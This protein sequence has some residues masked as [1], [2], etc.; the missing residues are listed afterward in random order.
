M[1]PLPPAPWVA[2]ATL[3]ACVVSARVLRLPALAPAGNDRLAS[4][5]GL[6]GMLALMVFFHHF[7]ITSVFKVSGQWVAPTS[8]V[9]NLFGTAGVSLFF[10]ITGF[11][12]FGKIKAVHG[13]IDLNRFFIGRFFRIVPVY[14]V[15]VT[16]VYLCTF[17]VTGFRLDSPLEASLDS[18]AFF[19]AAPINGYPFSPLINAGVVWTLSYE[20]VFYFSIPIL[21]LLWRKLGL[22]SWVLALAAIFAF[23]CKRNG[24]VIPYADLDAGL[25]S[26]FV[27]GGLAG[28]VV[29]LTPVRRAANGPWGTGMAL[30]AV[31]L[32]FSAFST[33]YSLS[34]F[35]VL[36]AFFVP[37]AAGNSLF[38]L[39][40]MRPVVFLGEVSY[41]IYMLHGI[42]LFLMFT[43]LSPNALGGAH[44]QGRLLSLML[45][46]AAGVVGLSTVVH[47]LVERPFLLIGRKLAPIDAVQ[48]LA[49]P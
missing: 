43:L 29:R 48:T 30:A 21:A 37:V 28:E 45:I 38:G 36:F 5:D 18:W 41:G 32:L 49:A 6:R 3:A 4:I 17:A 1:P 2:L 33:A 12:F 10:M 11:L 27:L 24:I 19:H 13:T 25:F 35:L 31:A 47:I 42:V 40:R 15:S 34:A 14:V 39:L 8:K 22:R 23:Y 44:S 9:Y 20:W 26:P 16:L 7:Y 46:A